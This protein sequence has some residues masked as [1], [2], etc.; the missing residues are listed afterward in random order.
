MTGRA[1]SFSLCL[2][3]KNRF[4]FSLVKQMATIKA[5]SL[6]YALSCD[7]TVS[8]WALTQH[9]PLQL[10]HSSKRDQIQSGFAHCSQKTKRWQSSLPK[11]FPQPSLVNGFPKAIS[12]K[13]KTEARRE[14]ANN[15][16]FLPAH[17]CSYRTWAGHAMY[18]YV[19][20]QINWWHLRATWSQREATAYSAPSHHGTQQSSLTLFL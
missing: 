13:G 9:I 12:L 6:K 15:S 16:V 10:D 3:N 11:I 18:A 20:G 4:T 8:T 5:W 14:P 17:A 7:V 1:Q 19:K 2:I